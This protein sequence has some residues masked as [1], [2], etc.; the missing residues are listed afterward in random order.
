MHKPRTLAE[1]LD[2]AAAV[3][4]QGQA[5]GSVINGLFR[6]RRGIATALLRDAGRRWPGVTVEK[7]RYTQDGVK[8]LI[9]LVKRGE[10]AL[11]ADMPLT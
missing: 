7:Q 8:L 9:A 1:M 3:D 11:P 5:F 4:D 2:D 6:Q 10:V